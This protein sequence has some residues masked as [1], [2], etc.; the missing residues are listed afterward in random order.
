M[1]LPQLSL[2][3]LFW[4]VLVCG[5]VVGWWVDRS[6]QSAD[7]LRRGELIRTLIEHLRLNHREVFG[8]DADGT[9]T[10]NGKPIDIAPREGD[11]YDF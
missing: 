7:S 5:L 10:I 4:L 2:R 8:I 1:K 11:L 9:W 6:R 3:D